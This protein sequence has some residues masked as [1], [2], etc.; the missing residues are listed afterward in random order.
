MRRRADERGFVLSGTALLLVLPAMILTSSLITVA[1]MGGETASFQ[2]ISDKVFYTGNDISRL[3]ENIWLDNVLFDNENNSNL[4]FVYMADNYASVSGLLVDITPTWMF[5]IYVEE[6]GENHRAGTTYG[7]TQ[8][9][10]D[11]EWRYWFEDYF[12]GDYNDPTL[13]ITENAGQMYIR[14]ESFSGGFHVDVY[15]GENKL[16]DNI[17]GEDNH[18]ASERSSW[19]F[20][21]LTQLTVAVQVTDATS[22]ARYAFTENF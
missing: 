3:V 2:A 22:T 15:Y 6:T 1:W 10:R 8:R 17:T 12:D 14:L 9:L 19:V 16:W 7:K 4:D 11:N 5:W 21:S 18:E 20:D 13:V